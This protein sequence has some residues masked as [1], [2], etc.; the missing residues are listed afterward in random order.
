MKTLNDIFT[1]AM[2]LMDELDGSGSAHNR[3]T[4]PYAQ[5]APGIVNMMAAEY[6]IL[7]GEAGGFPAWL[8]PWAACGRRS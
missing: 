5:R 8:W 4:E 3:E 1:A 7:S 6:R 2:G